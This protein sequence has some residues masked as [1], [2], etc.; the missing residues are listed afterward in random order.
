[1]F[2]LL[3]IWKLEGLVDSRELVRLPMLD[4][5]CSLREVWFGSVVESRVYWSAEYEL[6]YMGKKVTS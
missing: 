3:E 1:M 5:A 6:W 2:L 4:L